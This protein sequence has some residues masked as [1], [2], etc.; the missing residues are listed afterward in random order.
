MLNGGYD[1]ICVDQIIV[2]E[3]GD[4]IDIGKSVAGGGTVVPVVIKTLIF[5]TE[6]K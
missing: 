5:E 4:Y 2:N 6:Q 3:G 1:I